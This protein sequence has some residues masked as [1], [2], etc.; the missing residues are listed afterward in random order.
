MPYDVVKTM[1]GKTIYLKEIEPEIK[2]VSNNSLV[3]N[4]H[5]LEDGNRYSFVLNHQDL[6]LDAKNSTF[7]W[8]FTEVTYRRMGENNVEIVESSVPGFSKIEIVNLEL[9]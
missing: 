9:F 2:K 6:S 4:I 8:I 5:T 7:V 3:P 1:N